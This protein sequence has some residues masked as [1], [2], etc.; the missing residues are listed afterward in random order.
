MVSVHKIFPYL[1][2]QVYDKCALGEYG[3]G[4]LLEADGGGRMSSE[5]RPWPRVTRAVLVEVLI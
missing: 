1:I 5:V 4:Q 3:G 2:L